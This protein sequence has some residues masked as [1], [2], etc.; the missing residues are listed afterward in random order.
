MTGKII[1]KKTNIKK[2]RPAVNP[3]ENNL[4]VVNVFLVQSQMIANAENVSSKINAFQTSQALLTL[5]TMGNGERVL[6]EV[7][8]VTVGNI[9]ASN[10]SSVASRRWLWRS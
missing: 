6:N 5:Q 9:F 10:K 7:N 8:V 3:Y 1:E 2:K 4:N